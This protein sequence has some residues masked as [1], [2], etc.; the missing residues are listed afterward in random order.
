MERQVARAVLFDHPVHTVELTNGRIE[1][2]ILDESGKT[3]IT[4]TDI[5]SNSGVSYRCNRCGAIFEVD[6]ATPVAVSNQNFYTHLAA[7]HS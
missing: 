6:A 4:G 1:H 2:R 5:G 3:I 7:N